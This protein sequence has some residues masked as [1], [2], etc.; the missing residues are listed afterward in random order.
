MVDVLMNPLRWWKSHAV[1]QESPLR[2][3]RVLKIFEFVETSPDSR[4]VQESDAPLPSSIY[5]GVITSSTASEARVLWS[6]GDEEV[7]SLL[8]IDAENCL[9]RERLA[10][11]S[12]SPAFA[13]PPSVR[14][15][16]VLGKGGESSA[17]SPRRSPRNWTQSIAVAT[18]PEAVCSDC[19]RSFPS[20]SSLQSHRRH[21]KRLAVSSA[22]SKDSRCALDSVSG[23]PTACKCGATTHKRPNHR[24][25]PLNKK[26]AR[27]AQQRA[28]RNAAAATVAAE[29]EEE[30]EEVFDD[31]D[32][33]GAAAPARGTLGAREGRGPPT[34]EVAACDSS[35][36]GEWAGEWERCWVARD[37]G[38]GRADAVGCAESSS[39]D[40]SALHRL[41]SVTVLDDESGELVDIANVAPQWVRRL[42][43]VRGSFSG[44]PAAC[45]CGASTHT[46][47]NHRSCP[48]NK[49]TARAARAAQLHAAR[50][51]ATATVAAEE[52]EV[53]LATVSS[54]A[55]ACDD[56]R[57]G[58]AVY[59]RSLKYASHGATRGRVLRVDD[60]RRA[61]FEPFLL[62]SYKGW[63]KGYDE[64][65][66][67]ENVW[68]SKAAA[69]KRAA[70]R[71]AAAL[72]EEEEGSPEASAAADAD[73]VRR[74]ARRRLNGVGGV[75]GVGARWT[76]G[77]PVFVHLDGHAE[78]SPAV[79]HS[80]STRGLMLSLHAAKMGRFM[81][82]VVAA[83]EVA[84]RVVCFE[85]AEEAEEAAAEA[86]AGAA[87]FLNILARAAE[88]ALAPTA[89]GA[90]GG[91]P[92]AEDS[93]A[94]AR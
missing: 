67:E 3:V 49:K 54:A 34:H 10:A 9:A 31:S 7:L 41:L 43:A 22:A 73:G 82:H 63:K 62:V 81:T 42:S 5:V 58:M 72:G 45:K 18:T 16:V 66:G 2:G 61:C 27:A 30:V 88:D 36:V 15:K 84:Q 20:P 89:A 50:N 69:R 55:T 24:S 75:N 17:P 1:A 68:R 48:L 71:A 6:D 11:N 4:R 92:R 44:S 21:C 8:V 29:E 26:S 28:A 53:E 14:R 52:A 79:V 90:S 19:S 35:F 86:A 33:D 32:S 64:W 56:W 83:S 13:T 38:E 87:I 91:D 60:D 12:S 77:T 74:L 51:A 85:G 80:V 40:D 59:A 37:E 39:G 46:R 78:A 70:P 94:L 47:T 25:C 93:G 57:P 76:P 65:L 23:S